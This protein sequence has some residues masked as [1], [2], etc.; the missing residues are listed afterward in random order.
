MYENALIPVLEADKSAGDAGKRD[1]RP[2]YYFCK[3]KRYANYMLM[4]GAKMVAVQNDKFREGRVVF[5]F[6]WDDVCEANHKKW[7]E[8]DKQTFNYVL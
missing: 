6:L 1:K 7:I 2:R 3:S 5:V 8:G 4:N